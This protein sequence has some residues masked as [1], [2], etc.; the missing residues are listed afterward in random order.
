MRVLRPTPRL[1]GAA[2]FSR[3]PRWAFSV[4]TPAGKWRAF[5]WIVFFVTIP[6]IETAPDTG[7]DVRFCPQVHSLVEELEWI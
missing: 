5:D 7:V 4:S 3:I 6:S 1:W 2:D